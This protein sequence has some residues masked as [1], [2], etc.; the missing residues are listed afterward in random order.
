[1]LKGG[2]KE[3]TS[4]EWTPMDRLTDDAS[5]RPNDFVVAIGGIAATL[6]L[7]GRRTPNGTSTGSRDG[8]LS[9][10]GRRRVDEGD[11]NAPLLPSTRRD[12]D[13]SRS[14]TGP[15][16]RSKEPK[17][18]CLRQ[19]MAFVIVGGMLGAFA[20]YLF[21]S[22]GTSPV[23]FRACDFADNYIIYLPHGSLESQRVQ[24]ANALMLSHLLNRTLVLPPAIVS[25]APTFQGADVPY[26]SYEVLTKR[27]ASVVNGHYYSKRPCHS[28]GQIDSDCGMLP[29]CQLNEDA[30][31]VS[32]ET[33]RETPAS[34]AASKN[35]INGF[36]PIRLLSSWSSI[37]QYE[38]AAKLLNVSVVTDS[39]LKRLHP[40]ING[41]QFGAYEPNL[42]PWTRCTRVIRDSHETELVFAEKELSTADGSIGR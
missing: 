26:G 31:D 35:K 1:M 13:H 24:L 29:H 4:N 6:G 21:K 34:G 27:L 3:K 28:L 9:G 15:A 25:P 7:D 18:S 19:L 30:L 41:L 14:R 42:G 22:N 37:S 17:P 11:S 8:W 38:K 20:V 5:D 23:T 40:Q 12:S 33:K 2:A 16:F 10:G 39:D 32:L 36:L